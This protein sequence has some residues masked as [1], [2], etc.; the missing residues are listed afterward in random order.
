MEVLPNVSARD[1]ESEDFSVLANIGPRSPP[2]AVLYDPALNPKFTKGKT[3]GVPPPPQP[4]RAVAQPLN[5]AAFQGTPIKTAVSSYPAPPYPTYPRRRR[6]L[7]SLPEEHNYG[8]AN[9]LADTAMYPPQPMPQMDHQE[10][11]QNIRT[12]LQEQVPVQNANPNLMPPSPVGIHPNPNNI[13]PPPP[14][15]PLSA[16]EV[17]N[18]VEQQVQQAQ[19]ENMHN[20]HNMPATSLS[21]FSDTSAPPA[22]YASPSLDNVPSAI[23]P[24]AVYPQ[25][26][27]NPPNAVPQMPAYAKQDEMPP[28]SGYAPNAML[29]MSNA[30]SGMPTQMDASNTPTGGY[31]MPLSPEIPTANAAAAAGMSMPGDVS[32]TPYAPTN[33][34]Y[35]PGETPPAPNALQNAMPLSREMPMPQVNVPQMPPSVMEKPYPEPVTSNGMPP[36]TIRVGM[37]AD[38]FGKAPSRLEDMR[39]RNAVPP[40][41]HPQASDVHNAMLSTAGMQQKVIPGTG[42][43]PMAEPMAQ[44]FGEAQQLGRMGISAMNRARPSAREAPFLTSDQGMENPPLQA[45]IP[46]VEEIPL[47]G[48]PGPPE[49][50]AHAGVAGN[51]LDGMCVDNDK[52]CSCGKVDQMKQEVED[53]LFVVEERANPMVCIKRLCGPKLVCACAPGAN[54]LCKKSTAKSILVTAHVARHDSAEDSSMVLCRKESLEH[55][56]A[57]LSEVL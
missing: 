9:Q 2:D 27:P 48:I 29:D 17:I 56:I 53:C 21:D 51:G 22:E 44:R 43:N 6:R 50:P 42:P 3:S 49:P 4:L 31:G 13:P 10:Q 39:M 18:N 5:L 37:S 30:A 11:L 45:I 52:Y 24:A 36:A 47:P 15:A 16:P 38:M 32:A 54:A 40:R 41:L 12:D 33:A 26:A 35:M 28:A 25:N 34:M 20:G 55:G 8:P 57:I 46:G 19:S 1:G 23:A 7:A 14:M